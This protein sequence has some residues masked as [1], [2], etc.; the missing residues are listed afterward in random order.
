MSAFTTQ[1]RAN[2]PPITLAQGTGTFTFRVEASDLWDAVRVV[3]N[4]QTSVA[5]VKRR[6]VSDFFPNEQYVED[7][8]L[9]FRG[10]EVLDENAA[11]KDVGIVEGSILLLAVRRRRAVR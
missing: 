3:A 1:L 10:W 5:E 4:A 9:K 7:Y 2:R 8:V 6:A 11:L